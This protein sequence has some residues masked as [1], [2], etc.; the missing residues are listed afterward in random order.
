[1]NPTTFASSIRSLAAS[2]LVLFALMLVPP[3]S[4]AAEVGNHAIDFAGVRYDHPRSGES[5]W[6][7]SVTSGAAPAISHVDFALDFA[8]VEVLAAGTW[9]PTTD[10]LKE[11]AGLPKVGADPATGTTVLKFDTGFAGGETR[12]YYFTIGGAPAIGELPVAVKAS[13]AVDLGSVQGP[14]PGCAT[15]SCALELTK[16]DSADPVNA[17]AELSYALRY[18]NTGSAACTS[19]VVNEQYDAATTH[20]SA[21]PAPD[22]G[23]ADRWS[24]GTVEPGQS[25]EIVVAVAVS[26]AV[27]GGTVLVNRA[28]VASA[29]GGF[30]EAQQDTT[31]AAVAPRTARLWVTKRGTPDPVS[32]GDFITYRIEYG[33]DGDATAYQVVLTEVLGPQLT[34]LNAQPLPSAPSQ[35]DVGDLQPGQ[36]GTIFVYAQTGA[37][38]I[39]G[40]QVRNDVALDGSDGTP[41]HAGLHAR[42]SAVTTVSAGGD[43][44]GSCGLVV[45][46]QQ[47]GVAAAGCAIG[48]NLVWCDPCRDATGVVVTAVL[49][50][51]LQFLSA[52]GTPFPLVDGQTLTWK[53]RNGPGG[54]RRLGRVHGAHPARRR[55]GNRPADILPHDRRA[56]PRN[57]LRQFRPRAGGCGLLRPPRPH[58]VDQGV[59]TAAGPA[60]P[61]PGRVQERRA[62]QR[63]LAA[64]AS[65]RVAGHGLSG[66]IANRRPPARVGRASRH[67]RQDQGRGRSAYR[68]RPR[69]HDGG[70]RR[71]ARR[72]RDRRLGQRAVGGDQA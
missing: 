7:Y 44:V 37:D 40:T 9:G 10:D 58:A 17:G 53:R 48:F 21:L 47:T 14:A 27:P 28:S 72:H 38:L 4:R 5:T 18:A 36:G 61:L 55:A 45:R 34:F 67:G 25:G 41:D 23:T 43:T 71:P 35:W 30:A 29:N 1:M 54:P 13:G 31:V 52:T 20:V 60:R 6:Y 68:H 33:N 51:E 70:A 56:R 50:A 24:V 66:T 2:I 16:T 39:D 49:P 32:P 22:S 65:R 12:G 59:E 8:C 42:A 15:G 69:Q 62:G 64:P 57:H 3:G 26:A 63:T 46:A 11:G 19:V